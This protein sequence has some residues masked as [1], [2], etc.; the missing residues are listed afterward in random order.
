VPRVHVSHI[1]VMGNRDY[2]LVLNVL[3]VQTTAKSQECPFE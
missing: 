3:D 2:G 1:W